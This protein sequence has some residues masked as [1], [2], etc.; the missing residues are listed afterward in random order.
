MNREEGRNGAQTGRRKGGAWVPWKSRLMRE[1]RDGC[2]KECGGGGV[3]A[4]EAEEVCDAME[5]RADWL[6]A[7]SYCPT[8]SMGWWCGWT[9]LGRW[10]EDFLSEQII[11]GLVDDVGWWYG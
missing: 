1:E 4:P 2:E 3:V 7:Q 11:D 9:I 8:S 10:K 6:P 5:H